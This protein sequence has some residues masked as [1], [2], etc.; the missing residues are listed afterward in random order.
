MKFYSRSPR[1]LWFNMMYAMKIKF[2]ESF[3]TFYDVVYTSETFETI[4]KVLKNTKQ[5]SFF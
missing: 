3:E 4:R 5:T 1:M 2:D